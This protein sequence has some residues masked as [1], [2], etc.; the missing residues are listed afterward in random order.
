[1]SFVAQG[2]IEQDREPAG[3]AD[4]VP[5]LAVEVL[6][7]DGSVTSWTRLA[8]T[9]R[10]AFAWS[11]SSTLGGVPLRSTAPSRM[12]VLSARR[13]PWT[14]RTSCPAFAA[15][16]RRSS[17]RSIKVG[18]SFPEELIAFTD[19]EAGRLGT[20]RSGVL[21]RLLRAEQVRERARCYLDEHGWDV[22]DD[23]RAWR[24][25]QRRRMADEYGSDDW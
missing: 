11:G 8:S 18:V 19:R 9:C 5:D 14:E 12:P 10:P 20:S 17:I 2:R 16:W 13:T 22:V 15:R 1:V 6:S 25:C 21:A 23:E 24:R 4:V 7:D 3:Y